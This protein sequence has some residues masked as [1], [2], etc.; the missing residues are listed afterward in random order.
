LIRKSFAAEHNSPD[1][2]RGC[3]ISSLMPEN[4]ST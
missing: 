4:T 1:T 3:T 2:A